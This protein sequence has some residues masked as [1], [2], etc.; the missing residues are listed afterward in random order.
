MNPL[1]YL[2]E[3]VGIWN[4][5]IEADYQLFAIFPLKLEIEF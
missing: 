5:Q 1:A 3:K 2:G 4:V